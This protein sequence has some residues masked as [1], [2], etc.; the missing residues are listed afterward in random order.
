MVTYIY[1]N[2]KT[3]DIN[4]SSQRNDTSI[5][6]NNVSTY[7]QVLMQFHESNPIPET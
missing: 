5:I 2:R 6:H 1:P 4:Q 3:T 7:T